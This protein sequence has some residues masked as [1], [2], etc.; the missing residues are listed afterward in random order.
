MSQRVLY[1]ASG[2]VPCWRALASL[3]AKKLSFESRLLAFDKS[4]YASYVMTSLRPVFKLGLL[5]RDNCS[6]KCRHQ[7]PLRK[8]G[9]ENPYPHVM[10]HTN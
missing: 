3:K 8:K 4:E 7:E 1:W 10:L 9:G 6:L 2:S 5:S